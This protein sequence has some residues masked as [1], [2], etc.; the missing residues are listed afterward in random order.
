VPSNATING[1]QVDVLRESTGSAPDIIYDNSALIVKGGSPTG[2]E[3]AVQWSPPPW[4]TSFAYASYGNST[5]LWGTTWLPADINASNFGFALQV[6]NG[7]VDFTETAYVD[8]MR[9]TVWY[10]TPSGTT[11]DSGTVW[12]TV[13]GP[14]QINANYGQGDTPYSVAGKLVQAINSTSSLV[15]AWRDSGCQS[16]STTCQV[17][18]QTLSAGSNTNY[19]LSSGSSSSNG[20]SPASFSMSGGNLGGGG[21]AGGTLT[22]STF[23]Q[24]NALGNLLSVNQ[25]YDSTQGDWRTRTFA[26]DSL[27]RLQQATNPESG[28]I[29]Y[30]SLSGSTCQLNGYDANGNLISKTD[31]RGVV[32]T[33]TYDALNRLTQKSYNDGLTATVQY[34]YD[35]VAPT[36]CSPSLTM[37]NPI[38]RRT[39]M[40]DAAGNEAWSYDAMGRPVVDQRTTNG[41]IM[42]TSY[43]QTP[44]V[45]GYNFD[46]SIA[47]ISYPSGRTVTYTPSAASRMLS[48]VDTANNVN[49]ATS[50]LYIPPGAV[51]SMTNGTA[52]VSDYFN[53]RLQPCR[54]AVNT[55]GTVPT[56][57]S[58][59]TNKG[60][61][62]DLTYNFG[63]G[64][65]N[66]NVLGI[67]NNITS[68]RSL[69]A[70]YDMLNRIETAYTPAGA[71]A[72]S[73]QY[74][75]DLWGNLTTISAM[76]GKPAGEN[77]SQ[78]ATT[79]NRFAGMSYD[80]AGNLLN[81]GTTAY[82]F[83]A[84]NRIRTAG[85]T[86]YAYDG[87]G[88][89]VAK[90]SGGSVYK[91]YWYGMNSD[92][93]DET[94]G[95]GSLTNASFNEYVFFNGKRVARRDSASN[96]F[97]YFTDH[98]GTSREIVQAGQTSPCYDADF[99][100][101]GRESNVYTNSCPQNYK[102]TGKERDS[103]SGLDNFTAR[104]YSSQYGR[105]MSPDPLAGHTEDPQTLNRY[106][107]VRNNPLSLT[108]PT[109]LDF[110]LQCQNSDH[111]DCTQV[112]T[113]PNNNK[114][115]QWVQANQNGNATIIT[116]DS[117]RAGDNT[118]T[119]SE[120]GVTINGSSQ[121]IYFD[122]PASH[123]TDA[124]GND[125]NN[126]PINLGGSGALSGFNFTIN[127]NCSGT[128]LSSGSWSYNG[129]LNAA[130]ATLDDRGSF[131][132]LGP[133]EDI[134]AGFG[135]GE[136]AY[137]TQ[138]RF[139]GA[140]CSFWG[141]ANSPHLSVPYDPN[142]TLEPR[143]NVPATGGFHVDAHGD[144]F[145]HA[146][147]VSSNPQP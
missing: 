130:R 27:S 132:V 33:Y 69:T 104:Y 105:F 10:T 77:L 20:F 81:D 17:D 96:V 6:F 126:N 36:G 66:G 65:D 29:C 34:G 119:V 142:G 125:V 103:E 83:D 44:G 76:P 145:H 23:Y 43:Y 16:T 22:A 56:A 136:H 122:N 112:Q 48:A 49:Y 128:C 42:S 80:L 26:Y 28:T 4:P 85:T 115:Q 37:A 2:T 91:I 31:T 1:V 120:N 107:Y 5:D 9:I 90:S 25:E 70:S 110:Y 111:S 143:N 131:R 32:T 3:H 59:S 53:D 135:F 12:V 95:T 45:L 71:N 67:T 98:L 41:V 113:D 38:G 7:S 139:G 88:M 89:R 63:L 106:T 140:A 138:H 50:A 21:D 51:R 118:A 114:S 100:P 79:L 127:G 68:G 74:G 60:N 134:R 64:A 58:D 75:I 46:G 109:G 52:V 92:P 129:S 39:V 55:S 18:L 121:G 124:N 133:L 141:C 99:Y 123:T 108:D 117:I 15:Q 82:T 144:V 54:F 72:W 84:E 40:C 73:E 97:Y 93:L 11:Y 13:N 30:G 57:C 61:V 24:Y 14:P 35:A 147:D 47:L 94:D 116:S 102:F 8:F 62:L 101:L 78:S 19:S 87:D 137:S 86:T 146:Q